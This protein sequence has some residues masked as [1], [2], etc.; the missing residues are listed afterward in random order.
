MRNPGRIEDCHDSALKDEN[1]NDLSNCED[2]YCWAGQ[3]PQ[4]DEQCDQ[5]GDDYYKESCGGTDCHDDCASCHPDNPWPES[6]GSNSCG[7]ELDNDCDG[8]TDCADPDCFGHAACCVEGDPPTCDPLLLDLCRK[9][10]V[11][12]EGGPCESPILI[13][14]HGNGFSLTSAADGVLF[15]LDGNG[16]SRMLGWTSIGSDDAWLVLDRNGN[17]YVDDGTEMFGNYTPQ[18]APPPG[19]ERNGFLALAVFDEP[20]NGGNGDGRITSHDW[21]FPSLRLWQDVNHN[22]FSESQ[23][24]STLSAIG[25]A[26]IDLDYKRSRRTDQH[27]NHFRY[28]AK[29]RDVRGAQI[30]RW[31][32]DVYLVSENANRFSAKTAFLPSPKL[33][34]LGDPFRQGCGRK[35][36]LT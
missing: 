5:D 33:F 9:C 34:S 2:P 13:D 29:V 11:L 14:V 7:D 1:C 27:G 15:D 20:A 18:P 31:A 16:T 6:A 30:G 26:S 10:C 28:R 3:T 19:A 21:V 32:W 24:I 12:Q 35:A 4:C 23:E 8:L 36:K 17:G 22:G 25:L